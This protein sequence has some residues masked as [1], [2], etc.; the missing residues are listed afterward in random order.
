MCSGGSET[1]T[2]TC[3]P[4]EIVQEQKRHLQQIQEKMKQAQRATHY[5][6][7]CLEKTFETT[8]QLEQESK[9]VSA[10]PIYNKMPLLSQK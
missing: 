8:W 2:N 10:C 4:T 5:F 9:L 7:G 1:A 6:V 3:K